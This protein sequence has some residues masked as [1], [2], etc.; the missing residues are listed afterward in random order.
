MDHELTVLPEAL[1]EGGY[2]TA[3]LGKWHIMPI[4]QDDFEN[5]YPTDHGFDIN[6]GGEFEGNNTVDSG[7][8]VMIR[9]TVGFVVFLGRSIGIR[10]ASVC[11]GLV[12]ASITVVIHVRIVADRFVL[13]YFWR[14]PKA[15]I[16]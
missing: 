11:L 5:H 6:V 7:W 3:F 4:G 9:L 2:T 10:I 14:W 13:V 12:V 15:P 8:G 1:K 16:V